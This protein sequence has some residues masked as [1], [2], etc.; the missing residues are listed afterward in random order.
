MS[1]PQDDEATRPISVA[2]LLARHGSIGSPPV[3][4]RRR[5]R[6]GAANEVSVA[7]LTGE[8]PVIRDDQPPETAA[9]AEPAPPEEVPGP[10]EPPEPAEPEPAVPAPEPVKFAEPQPRWPRSSPYVAHKTGPVRSSIPRPTRAAEDIVEEIPGDEVVSA[11]EQMSP[12]PVEGYLLD[13]VEAAIGA[14]AA[15]V[16]TAEVETAE[17]PAGPPRRR[18]LFGALRGR[19]S[20]GEAAVDETREAEE[21]RE[22]GEV[23]A[24]LAALETEDPEATLETGEG[25]DTE[26]AVDTEDTEAGETA[27]DLE[28]DIAGLAA[29]ERAPE[30][31][32]SRL[33]HG[34]WVA[35]QSVLAVAFGAALFVAFDQ[36][37]RWN[38]VVA[39]VLAALVTVSLAGAVRVVRKTEDIGSTLAAVAVGLLVTVGPLVLLLSG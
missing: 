5:R 11:A 32:A 31:A 33:L 19:L 4:G 29:V 15:E 37:W 24:A 30:S 9:E 16:E 39:L 34:A 17:E 18:G 21:T 6:R 8:I 3:T 1:G 14:A 22:A 13:A 20:R 36:L 38:S 35:V 2:E 28:P 23:V 26:A 25:A 27:T 12:D 7:E 10:A